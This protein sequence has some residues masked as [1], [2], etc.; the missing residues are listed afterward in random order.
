MLGVL[1]DFRF[2]FLCS[3]PGTYHL[4]Q[5]RK[6]LFGT[7]WYIFPRIKRVDIYEAKVAKVARMDS[8]PIDCG[9]SQ[10]SPSAAFALSCENRV[11]P[12]D[13]TG[14]GK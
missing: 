3:L 4:L 14:L 5:V 13:R 2:F 8:V 6:I 12:A 1:Q 11:G 7:E 10:L 9:R